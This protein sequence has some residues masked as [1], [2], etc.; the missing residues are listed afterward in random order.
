MSRKKLALPRGSTVV[1][2]DA[3]ILIGYAEAD[4][5]DTLTTLFER[6]GVPAFTSAW[7]FEN[8]LEI[9]VA[10]YPVNQRIVDLEWLKKAPVVDEDI[11]YVQNLLDAWGSEEGRDRG[12]AE[13][14][15]LCTR[16]GWTGI[17]DDRKA[18]GVPELHAHQRPF[19]PQMVHGAAL[20]A[21]A[22]AENLI[23]EGDAWAT[24]KKVEAR[25]D[26]PPLVPVSDDYEPA[27]AAAVQAIRKKRDL[28]GQPPWPILL[29]H[30]TDAIV[31]AAVRRRR[32]DLGA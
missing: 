13:I 30:G 26:D 32:E 14:V 11:L 10:K 27:F 28:L 31:R 19:K 6:A 21:A 16:H 2:L 1:G 8:E 22:V 15:A 23:S 7:L 29:T 25:Y 17:S 18:H 20:L 4:A 24:H 5:V 3:M 9:P 12:E